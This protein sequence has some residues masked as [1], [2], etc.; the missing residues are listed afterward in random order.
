MCN[1]IPKW[2]KIGDICYYDY[3]LK[4]IDSETWVQILGKAVCISLCFNVQGKGMSP[5]FPY[6]VRGKK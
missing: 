6:S 5:S 3:R 4:K 2:Q 1:L